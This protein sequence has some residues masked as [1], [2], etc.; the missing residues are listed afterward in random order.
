MNRA[1]PVAA[2]AVAV[3]A[4]L[5]PPALADD[6]SPAPA[7]AAAPDY[8]ARPRTEDKLML[9]RSRV[10]P[11]KHKLLIGGLA[12]GAAVFAG[13]GLYFHL[14]SRSI[15]NELSADTPQGTRW[16]EELQDKY[17]RGQLDGTLAIASYVIAGGLVGGVIAA[18]ILTDPGE[19]EVDL[20]VRPTAGV[21]PGGGAVGAAWR[22]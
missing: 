22:W 13:A 17:D 6:A 1:S 8:F 18:L 16:S 5:A 2:L 12:A 7:P 20:R 19:D 10:R 15:A 14:D 21:I 11:R 3:L 9:R 4:A